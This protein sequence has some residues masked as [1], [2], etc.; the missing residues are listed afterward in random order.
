M[1]KRDNKTYRNWLCLL[2][3]AVF[4][5]C[6]DE[7]FTASDVEGTFI[8]IRGMA[9][10]TGSVHSGTPEDYIIHT[11]RVLA[12][13][14]T[15]GDKVTNL[16]YNAHSGDII[17]HPIDA[18]S[19]DFVFLANE[20]AYQ[21]VRTLL[22]AITHYGDLNHIAYPAD[23]FSSEQIIPMMQEIK[24]V[25]VLS[26]GQ[27]ATLEDNTTVSI[28][29]LALERIGVRVDVILRAEDDLDQAFKGI[30]FSNL[31]NLVPLTATYDGPAI[32]RSVIRTFTVVDD[33]SYFTQGTPTAEWDWEKKVNRIILPANDPLSVTN[34][35]EAVNFTID[36]GDNYNPSCKLKIASN[37]VNYSLPKNTKLDLTG[38]IK[39][40]LMVNIEASEWENVD[41]D[42]NISGIKV[43]NVSDLEVSITD[44]NGARI[45]FTSNMP[46]VK[47]MP[48]LYV[49]AGGLAA[50]TE[51]VFNDLVL[52]NGDVKDS[53]TTIT[54]TTSRFSYIYDKASQTGTGY[55]DVLLDEQNIMGTQETYRIF[56]S[57]EDEDGGSLQR[58]IKVH[59]SQ[60]GKR[61]E[62][63]PYGTGY[64]GAF[65]RNDE[66]GERIITGQQKRRDGTNERPQDLG[67]LGLWKAEVE[68]GNFIVLSSTPSFDPNVGTDN[69]GVAEHYKVLPNKYK[70]E[71]GTYV[72]GRG[73]IYFRMGV[74]GKNTG[75]TPRYAKV[76]IQWY[77]GRYGTGD[78]ELWYNTEYMYIRQGEADDY[79]M[80]P[81]T[82]DAISKGPSQGKARD[83]ARKISPFNLTAPAYLNGGNEPY[84]KVDVKQGRFVKYPTQAGAFFQWGLPKDAD[85]D[86]FRL[87][88][89]PTAYTVNHWIKDIQFFNST[90][91]LFLPVWGTAPIPAE[92]IYDY[93][94][95][96]IFETCPDGYHRPSDGYIDR[97]AYNGPYP[98][99]IDQD[100]DHVIVKA[101]TNKD[102]IKTVL[103]DYSVEIA[104]SELR[105][106]LFKNPLSGDAGLNENI[107][108]Y[109]GSPEVGGIKVDRYQN[110]WQSRTDV[111]EAQEHITFL[112]GFY[113]DG[114]FDRR[115]I[116][117]G[118]ADGSY[119]Y[120]VSSG[121][122]QAA[123]LGILV[124]NEANNASV[125]FPSAGRRQNK[126]SSLEF[127]GQTGYYHTASIA[128]SS[129]EDPHAVW[130][131]SL[132][133]W[134][135]PGLM[136]Q[137]PT[138]GQ[139][140]RCV[141]D[142][143]ISRK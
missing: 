51:K 80:R 143:V 25:T 14:K 13:D 68:E 10:H 119:P 103:T 81:G 40:P 6:M 55:M 61:F 142:E 58:E 89:H 138:F 121:N 82:V 127:A 66:Q 42:W 73:R 35:S 104:F 5:S 94:Y 28:L 137:L 41:E 132:G 90:S 48:Q 74:T 23:F 69:P 114:F 2:W 71:N 49:G 110:F 83:Y 75:T 1:M 26:G 39:E 120:C 20:P 46:V 31:P 98:N 16:F 107:G 129:A 85:Q 17:R 50:E 135:N 101:N 18:G 116:K 45:S 139:S 72:E 15:T 133:K 57:A 8:S 131:M 32:E 53:G 128:A 79:I 43:L 112:I 3:L 130:S 134:P 117:M 97:I 122:A 38:Y 100:G 27:G 106:S 30:M 56:L 37:P 115:P 105:Q 77:G 62:F 59:A 22:D 86:Y 33:G 65:F 52:L 36:M 60:H 95:K 108:G 92:D 64:I 19:Y 47:V 78:D 118:S 96:E 11:L 76:K 123:Y 44:F 99:N 113:A 124:Y 84:A 126:D 54:Y 21:P 29:Q 87:A 12:F 4:T 141:R 7:T 88:Y 125:F 67:T 136:Y 102:V 109:D 111:D 9:P 24:N 34:E 140:I 91:E 63:N 70:G 93:G